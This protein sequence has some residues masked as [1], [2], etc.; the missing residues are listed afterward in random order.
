VLTDH[1][2]RWADALAIPD[3][4]APT[5]ARARDQHVFCYFRLPEQIHTDQGAQFQ[6]QLMG[7]LCRIRG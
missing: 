3:A 2:N 6:S 7:D 1:F 4:S 5:V